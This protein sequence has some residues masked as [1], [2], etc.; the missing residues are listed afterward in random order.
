MLSEKE[1]KTR[2]RHKEGGTEW[3]TQI[4]LFQ[5]SQFEDNTERISVNESMN[6]FIEKYEKSYKP[7]VILG[8]ED[9]WKAKNKWTIEGLAKKYRN[10]KFAA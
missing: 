2:I 7:V 1:I 10:Q 3:D 9:N 5:I 8:V 4:R 6:K